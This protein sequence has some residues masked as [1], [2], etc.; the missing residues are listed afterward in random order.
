MKESDWYGVT[1]CSE[2]EQRLSDYEIIHS[3][4][5]C[6]KCGHNSHF[7]SCDHLTLVIKEIKHHK[8][9]QFWKR[10]FTYVGKDNFSQEWLDKQKT[11]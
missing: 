2:C 3:R 11:T 7:T 9:W 6:P 8:W 4:G 5:I 1:I 10:K